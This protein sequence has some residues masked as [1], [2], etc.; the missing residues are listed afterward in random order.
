MTLLCTGHFYSDKA[1]KIRWAGRV[2]YMGKWS[3]HSNFLSVC[4]LDS[5]G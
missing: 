3:V 5:Y 2:A 1:R 4:D